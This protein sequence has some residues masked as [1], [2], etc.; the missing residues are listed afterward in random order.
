MKENRLQMPRTAIDLIARQDWLKRAAGAAQPAV[1][2]AFKA[3]G[4]TGRKVKNFL[5]G[6]WWASAASFA[7]SREPRYVIYRHALELPKVG[8][9]LG[10]VSKLK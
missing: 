5:H 6:A 2:R 8:I 10:R 9:A 3:G 1:I 4:R 7:S